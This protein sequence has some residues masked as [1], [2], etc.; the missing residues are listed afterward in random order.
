MIFIFILLF[1][2]LFLFVNIR[3][4]APGNKGSIAAGLAVIALP[5]CFIFRNHLWACVGQ[6]FLAVWLCEALLLYIL[7]KEMHEYLHNHI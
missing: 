7:V 6:A 2:V 5:I 4:V 1:G 3:Q